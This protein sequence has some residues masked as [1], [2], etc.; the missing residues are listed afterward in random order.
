MISIV[1][2]VLQVL[3][4]S[5]LI[6]QM[7][8]DITMMQGQTLSTQ[9]QVNSM[10][11][12]LLGLQSQIDGAGSSIAGFYADLDGI[13]RTFNATQASILQFSS[14][15]KADLVQMQATSMVT[16]QTFQSSSSN[17][18]AQMASAQQKADAITGQLTSAQAT[19][20][21]ALASLLSNSTAAQAAIVS[22]AAQYTSAAQTSLQQLLTMNATAVS[23]LLSTRNEF[24]QVTVPAVTA[25][26]Q[27]LN[28]S[29]AI[30]DLQAAA[31]A[32][33]V[34]VSNAES[35]T[36]PTTALTAA[37]GSSGSI[38][39]A[40]S[41]RVG[42]IRTRMFTSS[43][44]Y[45]PTVG[46]LFCIIEVVGGGGTGAPQPPTPQ[47]GQAG[48]WRWGSGGWMGP[49]SVQLHD[50]RSLA[51]CH[52]GDRWHLAQSRWQQLCRQRCRLHQ[53]IWR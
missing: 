17:F 3:I 7:K 11:G 44:T 45:I 23:D 29:A 32:L 42:S 41:Q 51:T 27:S 25:S 22:T 43:G 39:L 24:V 35:L 16:L 36:G 38:Q 13:T 48:C 30:A 28:Q 5:I 20:D 37:I 34:R 12:L 49:W 4:L 21:R 46:M 47:V 26:L 15:T 50:N 40:L 52:S 19:V 33:T 1:A 2:I 8:N 14:S 18:S 31:D 6:P 53:R 10:Q 9:S